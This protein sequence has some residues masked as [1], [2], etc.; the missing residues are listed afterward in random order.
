M[1]YY[2]KKTLE[3]TELFKYELNGSHRQ[4]TI[5]RSGNKS[6]KAIL[7]LSGS[8][9]LCYDVY[10]QKMVADL[11][12]YANANTDENI[13]TDYEF[14]VFEKLDQS[15][16]DIYDDVAHFLNTLE[17]EELVLLGF[18]SGGVVASHIMSRL[19]SRKMKMKRKII[20]YDT[21][22][23]V[24]DNVLSFSK[25]L[26][27]RIDMLF[28]QIVHRV[29]SNHYNYEKIKEH[30]SKKIHGA[31]KMVSMIKS[32]HGYND[33]VMYAITGWKWDVPAE[34]K[35]INIFC[36]KDPFVNRDTHK[37]FV[38]RFEAKFQ[39]IDMKKNC[40]GHCT[41]MGYNTK[42]LKEIIAALQIE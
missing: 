10:I 13:C 23:Q 38:N 6:N 26:F 4:A 11:Q 14:M 17:L 30:L 35:V 3:K 15:S 33:E 36:E 18:S 29:Y 21:P 8:Y 12:E 42:Y 1:S 20:T 40:I 7:F 27:Y 9:N 37:R 34:L 16:I 22:W 2:S 25:N 5:Y 32:I 39:I 31:E 41:D 24:Q 28:F 19:N